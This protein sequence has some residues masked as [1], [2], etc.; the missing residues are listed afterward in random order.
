MLYLENGVHGGQ[1]AVQ[2]NAKNFRYQVCA[3]KVGDGLVDVEVTGTH[4][5]FGQKPVIFCI[6][7]EKNRV[8]ISWDLVELRHRRKK[9]HGNILFCI[10]IGEPGL[11]GNSRRIKQIS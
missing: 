6:R 11:S 8:F 1:L 3:Q 7:R 9:I 10:A 5:D 4:P 2:G